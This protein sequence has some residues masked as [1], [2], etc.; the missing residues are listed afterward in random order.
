M[1]LREESQQNKGKMNILIVGFGKVGKIRYEILKKKNFIKKIFIYDPFLNNEIKKGIVL[2]NLNNLELLNIKAVFISVPT[3]L[4][5][6]YTKFFLSLNIHVFCEKPPATKI[7]DLKIIKKI[8]KKKKNINLMYGF[9]H[10][11]HDSVK[12]ILDIIKKNKYGKVLWVRSRYGKPID[13]NYLKGWRG[14]KK[15]SGGGI[16]FDQGIHVLDLIILLLGKIIKVKSILNNNFIKKNIEDNAFIILENKK[17]QT[18]SIHSTLTQ[19]RHLFAIEIFFERGFAVLNGLKTPSGK[20]GQE[21]LSYCK[22]SKKPPEIKWL[23]INKKKYNVDKSFENE[24]NIFLKSLINK[25]KI[26]SCNIDDALYLMEIVNKI[27]KEN[28]MLN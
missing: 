14:N 8:L 12:K 1:I 28:K 11:H 27:Y 10:R 3:F 22:N 26:L 17:K 19:W 15:K 16:L 9:N 20:Y 23:K 6:K 21:V 18:A 13:N 7:N 24:T 25:K 2:D 5:A 4:A